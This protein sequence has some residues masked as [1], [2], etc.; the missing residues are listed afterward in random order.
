MGDFSAIDLDEATLLP[1]RSSPRVEQSVGMSIL[2]AAAATLNRGS[3]VIGNASHLAP[4]RASTGFH[5]SFRTMPQKLL[6]EANRTTYNPAVLAV[7]L[8]CL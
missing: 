6:A 1:S 7:I 5:N 4:L 3:D 8:I 2:S